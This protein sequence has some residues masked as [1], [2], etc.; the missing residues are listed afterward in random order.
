MGITTGVLHDLDARLRPHIA[1]MRKRWILPLKQPLLDGVFFQ[2]RY[3]HD[4]SKELF[5]WLVAAKS[6]LTR[7]SDFFASLGDTVGAAF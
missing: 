4:S 3:F 7:F 5:V 1:F 2:N 6:S